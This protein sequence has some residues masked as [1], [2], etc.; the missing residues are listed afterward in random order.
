MQD[1]KNMK[2]IISENYPAPL[3]FKL[4]LTLTLTRTLT[5]SLTHTFTPILTLIHFPSPTL[6][7]ILTLA[8]T[9][10]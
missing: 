4:S 6:N 10:V 7:F 8:L 3:L 1:M 5:I 9:S 2:G